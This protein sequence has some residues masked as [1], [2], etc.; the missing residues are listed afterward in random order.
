MTWYSQFLLDKPVSDTL[1]EAKEQYQSAAAPVTK[2]LIWIVLAVFASQVIATTLLGARSIQVLAGGS[3]KLFPTLA[4]LLAPVLHAGIGH[5]VAN[6]GSL[7][8]LGIPIEQY[9]SPRR[10]AFFIVATAYLSTAGGWLLQSLFTSQ[11][12]AMYGISGTAFALGGFALVKYGTAEER[13]PAYQLFALVLGLAALIIVAGDPFTG[14]YF[15]PD[16]INGGHV[17][18]FLIGLIAGVWR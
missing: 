18:G 1:R 9:F 16:W 15:H 14:P 12:I 17:T 7:Y 8:V 5:L 10:F 3:F 2:T 13:L 11:Q 4:W 6:I